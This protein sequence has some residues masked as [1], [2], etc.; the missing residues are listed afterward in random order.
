MKRLVVVED[1][2]FFQHFYKSKLIES[3]YEVEVAGDGSEGL[4]KIHSFH[5]DLIL[6]DLIMPNMDGFQLLETLNKD[7]NL[8]KI[9]IIIFSTLG[10]E[11]DIQKAKTL[12]ARDYIN[13]SYFDF[14]SLLT[15]IKSHLTP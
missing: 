3:G 8:K 6:L 7:E 10:Q 11:N 4:S 2:N 12:G 15:K 9:P 1:D 5:P 13:K 14:S